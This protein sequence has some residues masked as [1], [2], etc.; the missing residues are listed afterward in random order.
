MWSEWGARRAARVVLAL[1]F[2]AAFTAPGIAKPKV[3]KSTRPAAEF[4]LAAPFEL[5]PSL[6]ARVAAPTPLRFF[7]INQVLAK[8]DRMARDG[9]AVRL[10]AIDPGSG[11]RARRARAAGGV[12]RPASR[13]TSPPARVAEPTRRGGGPLALFGFRAPGGGGWPKG[14][15]ERPRAARLPAAR[16]RFAGRRV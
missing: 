8:R 16:R 11:N 2:A 7:S 9:D 5:L 10:A 1:A 6:P 15:G 12:G 4:G 13:R 14:R 3:K